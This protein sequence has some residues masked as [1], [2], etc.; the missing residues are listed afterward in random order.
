M[1]MNRTIQVRMTKDQYERIRNNTE[2]KG[3]HSM[4]AF[5]RFASLERDFIVEQKICEI[6]NFLIGKNQ[7]E[8]RRRQSTATQ[9]QASRR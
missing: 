9:A 7:L 8:V 6:Y 3:F 1:V 2:L 4:S 5:M